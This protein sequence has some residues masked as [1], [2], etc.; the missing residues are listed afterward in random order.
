MSRKGKC[1]SCFRVHSFED[2]QIASVAHCECGQPLF[3]CDAGR[4]DEIPVRCQQCHESYLVDK[5]DIGHEVECECG[6]VIEVHDLVLKMPIKD[7]LSANAAPHQGSFDISDNQIQS[8]MDTDLLIACPRCL[9]EYE[10]D[11]GDL[12]ESA[13]CECGACFKICHQN[14]KTVGVLL[15]PDQSILTDPT[16][17]KT[18]FVNEPALNPDR[19]TEEKTVTNSKSGSWWTR[20]GVAAVIAFFLFSLGAFVVSRNPA[21][22]QATNQPRLSEAIRRSQQTTSRD[23]ALKSIPMPEPSPIPA[24]ALAKLNAELPAPSGPYGSLDA[25]SAATTKTKVTQ[26]VAAKTDIDPSKRSPYGPPTRPRS[27][28]YPKAEPARERLPVVEVQRTRRIFQGAY[29]DAF[30]SYE[31]LNALSEDSDQRPR[32]LG[33]TIYLTRHALA[34]AQESKDVKKQAEVCYLL[35]YLSYTAGQLVEAS[36]YGEM[37]ARWGDKEDPATHEAAMIALASAQ[38]AFDTQWG[39]REQVGELEQMRRVAELIDNKW[40]KDKQHDAIWLNLAHAYNQ[41]GRPEK[42]AEAFLKIKPSSEDYETSLLAAGGAYWSQFVDSASVDSPDPQ[43]MVAILSR[44]SSHLRKGVTRLQQKASEPTI[45]ILSAKMTLATIAERFGDPKSALAWLS[46]EPIAVTESITVVKDAASKQKL[47]VEPAFARSVYQM[48]YRAQ[49]DLKDFL[50]AADSLDELARLTDPEEVAGLASMQLGLVSLQLKSLLSKGEIAEDDFN[51]TL[52]LLELLEPYQSHVTVSNELWL[53]DSW[54]QL[55]EMNGQ[56]DLSSQC[57]LQAEQAYARALQKE[58]FP[59]GSVVAMNVRRA[60][61]LKRAGKLAETLELLEGI[62]SETPNLIELQITAAM[63]LQELAIN[64]TTD[65]GLRSAIFGPLNEQ[66]QTTESSIWGWSKL[67]TMLHRL[68]YSEQARPEHAQDLVVAYYFLSRCQWLLANVVAD[69]TEKTTLIAKA[70]KQVKQWLSTTTKEHSDTQMW[71]SAM[72]Q[73][74]TRLET[75]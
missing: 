42:A 32:Q 75:S 64:D 35:A 49:K 9:V 2:G 25:T 31:A 55:A 59:V 24:N 53:A 65:L 27:L 61:L 44:A 34:L 6:A 74:L 73:L 36:I 45:T 46:E 3:V 30:E 41:F 48:M 66:G 18:S 10:L 1:P 68:K 17:S 70:T 11:Q 4:F 47:L 63:I 62:L 28:N 8:E 15:E 72:E 69:D 57:C 52:H 38:E 16:P 12:N 43:K 60:R 51:A 50:G 26:D 71:R 19:E 13:V 23:S 54:A 37:A 20:L 39:L 33:E 58:G 7:E 67:T 14:G 5:E 22:P 21:I 40:P 29:Q 56:K